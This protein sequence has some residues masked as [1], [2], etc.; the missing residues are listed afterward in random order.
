MRIITQGNPLTPRSN[1]YVNFLYDIYTLSTR[2][3][4]RI[5]QVEVVVFFQ[6]QI[7]TTNL[8]GNVKQ[9]VGRIKNQILGVKG[10]I[11]SLPGSHKPLTSF[12]FSL[13]LPDQICNSPYYQLYNFHG[14]STQN[15]ILDEL[16]IPKFIYSLF[17]ILIT[18]LVDIVLIL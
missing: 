3:V 12:P 16:V 1:Y 11:L 7:L 2:Q 9:L 14:V 5:Y 10:L 17:F 18:Y 8:Q 4:I 6:H 15:L 13:Q